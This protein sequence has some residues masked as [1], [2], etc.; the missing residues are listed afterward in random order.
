LNGKLLKKVS[1]DEKSDSVIEVDLSAMKSGVYY[2]K[3]VGDKFTKE[4]KVVVSH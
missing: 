2:F 4:L 3:L 1:M